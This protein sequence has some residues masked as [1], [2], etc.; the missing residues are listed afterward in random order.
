MK[1]LS[2][3]LFSI[4]IIS[5]AAYGQYAFIAEFQ[6]GSFDKIDLITAEKT[7][8]GTTQTRLSA[9]DFGPGGVLFAIDE[10]TSN[11]YEV[12]TTDGSVNLLGTNPPPPDHKWTGMAYD[13]ESGIMYG[14]SHHD[15]YQDHYS[16]LH[17]IDVADG[18]YTLL[19]SQTDAPAIACIGI[20]GVGDLYAMQL[21]SVAKLYK[22]DKADGQVISYQGEIGH[23]A[24]GSA[25]GM[26]WS[27]SDSTMY[28][29]TDTYLALENTLRTIDL[30]N[31]N[32]TIV[33][34]LGIANWIGTIAVAP[35][36]KANFSADTT[37]LCIGGTVNFTDESSWASSWLWTFEGGSPATSTD[38][39]PSVTYDVAGIYD[40][41]LEVSNGQIFNTLFR[42]DM[43]TVKAIP[44]QPSTPDGP[45]DACGYGEFTYTTLSVLW[46]ETYL[47][48]VLPADAGTISGSGTS[49]IFEATG[50]WT[51]SYTVKVMASN[52]CGSGTWSIEL[53]CTLRFAPYPFTVEGG[54]NYCEGGQGFEVTLDGSEIDMDYELFNDGFSTEIVLEGTGNPLNFGYQT[55]EGLY[56]VIAYST[57]CSTL[58]EGD[59]W[60]YVQFLPSPASQPTGPNEVCSNTSA[61]YQTEAIPDA[62]TINWLLSPTHAGIVIGS[63]LNISI[64]WS[65]DYSGSA[66]LSVYGSNDC[67]D[68]PTS[69]ELEISV[70]KSPEPEVDGETI[71][72]LQHEIIYYTVDNQG[73]TYAW[74]VEGGSITSGE[75]T[76]EISTLWTAIGAGTVFVT[77]TS[78]DTC[79]VTSDTLEVIVDDCIGIGE[80][81]NAKIHLYPN[82]AKNQIVISFM[83]TKA[84][85]YVANIFN[86]QGQPVYE[87][88][89]VHHGGKGLQQINIDNLPDGLY[90]YR[91]KTSTNEVYQSKFSIIH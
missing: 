50:D 59:A 57:D 12:D 29:T 85:H 6:V 15:V 44:A 20:D 11:F 39:N 89:S 45:I 83:S 46:A 71:V 32:T 28:L 18:S 41:T 36:L 52:T 79:V 49:A 87:K 86:Q 5:S 72:C 48:E 82:P 16:S 84:M 66:Y 61:D 35:I 91:I 88:Q 76:S 17:T 77:E 43:I 54:G 63:G 73:S 81:T 69:D 68:G 26:D 24:A 33:G 78:A 23:W 80:I 34:D 9:S 74:S 27:T 75:G 56:T 10:S 4:C 19:G 7:N 47:W 2:V 22:L 90:I 70:F 40:V 21:G 30:S 51:G 55:D 42:D 1:K 67:G 60:I 25:H 58:M 65:T 53:N 31:G 38:Q 13:E 37:E 8:I 14:I 62:E 64:D 3:L